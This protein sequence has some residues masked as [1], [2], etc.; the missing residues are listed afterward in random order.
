MLAACID[1]AE[2][3]SEACTGHAPADG[4]TGA[5]VGAAGYRVSRK[6]STSASAP[7]EL[8][9]AACSF[10]TRGCWPSKASLISAPS[11]V[12]VRFHIPASGGGPPL[13][14][15]GGDG[16]HGPTAARSSGGAGERG[17][18]GGGARRCGNGEC[19]VGGGG[20]G[21]CL[22][23]GLPSCILSVCSSCSGEPWEQPSQVGVAGPA[24]PG[25]RAGKHGRG[26]RPAEPH[27]PRAA[28]LWQYPAVPG[29]VP[30]PERAVP[31]SPGASPFLRTYTRTDAAGPRRDATAPAP[32][33]G[34]LTWAGN[35][36]A[37]G[38]KQ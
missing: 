11:S 28:R 2:A 17:G 12:A 30:V 38:Q 26:R 31:G 32:G 33:G 9:S 23:R 22:V 14:G 19:Q 10:V 6:A 36:K 37:S 4:T 16:A 29:V 27:A 25:R 24:V 1:T 13:R 21:G 8:V 34:M 15:G 18:W 20:G 7:L 35:R 3:G 5:G